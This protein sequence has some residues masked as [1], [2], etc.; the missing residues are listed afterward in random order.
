MFPV[1]G[2]WRV[3]SGQLGC[4]PSRRQSRLGLHMACKCDRLGMSPVARA[5]RAVRLQDVEL[6][7]RL[8]RILNPEFRLSRVTAFDPLLPNACQAGDLESALEIHK[9]LGARQP[10]SDVIECTTGGCSRRF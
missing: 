8:V 2:H 10:K 1:E 5:V 4:R 7:Q 9:F 3:A 6:P